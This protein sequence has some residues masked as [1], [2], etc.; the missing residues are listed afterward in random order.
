MACILK[1]PVHHGHQDSELECNPH[2]ALSSGKETDVAFLDSVWACTNVNCTVIHRGQG[3]WPVIRG[4]ARLGSA[5]RLLFRRSPN[6]PTANLQR[7]CVMFL[8]EGGA[9]MTEESQVCVFE[10]IMLLSSTFKARSLFVGT[11]QRVL[12]RRRLLGLFFLQT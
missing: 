4:A 2:I 12:Y 6:L 9:M 11:R 8:F 5:V 7:L 10:L 3:K 1:R